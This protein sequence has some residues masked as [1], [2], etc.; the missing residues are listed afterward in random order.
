V[1]RTFY[2]IYNGDGMRVK[3][4]MDTSAGTETT[5]FV[6]GHSTNDCMEKAAKS[7]M[8]PPLTDRTSVLYSR[9]H[10]TLTFTLFELEK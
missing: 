10:I 2:L 1:G 5:Y 7:P 6:G 9:L 4:I 3:S 8:H